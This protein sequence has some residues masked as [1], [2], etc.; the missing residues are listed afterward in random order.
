M[1]Y[2]NIKEIL[3]NSKH[4]LHII[5]EDGSSKFTRQVK[6]VKT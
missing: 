3:T 2:S 1:E 5:Y 4:I 6:Y